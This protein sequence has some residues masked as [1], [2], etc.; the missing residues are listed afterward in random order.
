MTEYKEENSSPQSEEVLLKNKELY[1][2]LIKRG[3]YTQ[4]IGHNDEIHYI[5]VSNVAP[6]FQISLEEAADISNL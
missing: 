2:E 4:F 1:K 5:I 6:K 3:F